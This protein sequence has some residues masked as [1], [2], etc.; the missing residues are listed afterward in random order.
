MLESFSSTATSGLAASGTG[1]DDARSRKLQLLTFTTLYPSAVQPRH[2][3]FVETRLRHL[4][5]TGAVE[6]RVVAPVPWFPFG[7]TVFG[8]YAKFARTPRTEDRSG[9]L[10]HH[11]R[12]IAIPRIGVLGQPR[13]LAWAAAQK[14]A[15]MV[16]EG[17]EFDAIDAHYF[18]PDGVAA[19]YLAKRFGKP[20]VVTARGSDIN[21]IAQSAR[22]RKM[23][24][25]AAR[26]AGRL[27]AVSAALKRAMIELGI[28]AERIV[29][30]RNGVDL[31]LFRPIPMS[32]ARHRLG[33]GPGRL[34]AS[35][36]NLVPEKGHDLV[37]R[38]IAAMHSVFG[39]IVGEGPDKR[40]LERLAIE[41][42]VGDRIRFLKVVPQDELAILY[43][44][45]DVLALGS[46]REGWPN[47][48]LEAMACGAPVVVT[49]V[50]G[51][52]EIVT[53]MDVGRIVGGRDSAMFAAAIEQVIT[54]PPD[55]TRIRR[56]AEGFGWEPVSLGQ[57]D[58]FAEL[59]NRNREET[60]V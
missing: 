11:P 47:V 12:Y 10:V 60:R 30:L 5:A 15:A 26:T 16:A 54:M 29:V 56:Y 46:V 8:R 22:P 6:A 7:A 38:A 55:R 35:V 32:D 51:V 19:A 28:E 34:V 33:L 43:S 31:E 4:I 50:G 42:G 18:F 40:R 24:L 13:S 48:L 9:L 44:A 57:L 20:F 53:N 39:V 21:L 36:G 58:L 14:I 49:D 37:I 41:S 25:D 1:A 2:G 17:Y 3:I 52:R 59:V 23:I 45:I 27:I